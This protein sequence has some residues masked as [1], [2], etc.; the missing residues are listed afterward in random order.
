MKALLFLSGVATGC[1]AIEG[2]WLATMFFIFL[3]L[4]GVIYEGLK[5]VDHDNFNESW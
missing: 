5:S 1:L 2:Y 4:I 3:I